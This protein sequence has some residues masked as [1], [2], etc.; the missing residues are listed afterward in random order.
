VVALH[1]EKHQMAESAQ[2]SDLV[3]EIATAQN[4]PDFDRLIQFPNIKTLDC[5]LGAY[6]LLCVLVFTCSCDCSSKGFAYG[7]HF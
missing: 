2:L 3:I 5:A 7:I 6:E 1:L 4:Y